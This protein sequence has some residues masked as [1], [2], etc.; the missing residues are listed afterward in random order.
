MTRFWQHFV[1][2]GLMFGTA[3]GFFLAGNSM[4]HVAGG[5]LSSPASF[6]FGMMVGA[7]CMSALAS[8]ARDTWR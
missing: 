8:H 5:D 2:V 4:C 6:F 1:G 3:A 7:L